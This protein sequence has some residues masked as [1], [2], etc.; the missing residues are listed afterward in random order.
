MAETLMGH[1]LT[2]LKSLD[3][4]LSPPA[5]KMLS[6]VERGDALIRRAELLI[7]LNRKRR[8]DSAMGDLQEAI[9]LSPDNSRAFCLL[10]HCYEVKE[11]IVEA[12]N[13]F[14]KSLALEP[15]LKE[16]REGL[17]RLGS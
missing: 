17:Q 13:A 5:V 11:M 10:G 9:G 4:A 12:R 14:E 15:G 1:K 3:L 2:A 6:E 7:G 16:A 8:V